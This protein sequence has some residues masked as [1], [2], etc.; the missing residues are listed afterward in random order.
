MS[1]EKLE[2]EEIEHLEEVISEVKDLFIS[3]RVDPYLEHLALKKKE[4]KK[5]DDIK[6]KEIPIQELVRQDLIYFMHKRKL[7]SQQQTST[8]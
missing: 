1:Y 6:K 5:G 7:E 8:S 3:H 4:I 2:L